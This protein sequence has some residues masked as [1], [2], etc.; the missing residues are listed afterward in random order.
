MKAPFIL[1]VEDDPISARLVCELLRHQYTLKVC[2]SGARALEL[3][4]IECP[5]LILMDI[6]MKGITGIDTC[7]RLK[8]TDILKHIPIIFL[9]ADALLDTEYDGWD[10]GCTDFIVKPFFP[11]IL[12]NR[13]DA[14]IQAKLLTDKLKATAYTDGLTGVHNRH[15]LNEFLAEQTKL[16]TRN[17]QSIG[18][19]MIDI[20]YFKQFNDT[21]GH[22]EGDDCLTQVAKAA[23]RCLERP[24][25]HITRYGGEE[26]VVVLPNTDLRGVVLVAEKIK[27]AVQKLN[28]THTNSPF[29]TLTISMGG[30]S[31]YPGA[32][33]SLDLLSVVDKQLYMAKNAGRNCIKAVD[34]R[35][36]YHQ[37]GGRFL[38]V[39]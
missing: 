6:E 37:G 13:V 39:N 16:S 7:K 23:Q 24:T 11:K 27:L 5:D 22:L 36:H 18:L 19:L 12:Q 21:Y 29:K 32:M 4:E 14:H 2:S 17:K 3:C 20:D 30:L 8:K 35:Q 1:V 34:I 38:T 28:I 33:D 25:D 31:A 10:A 15:F 26:F 9:T